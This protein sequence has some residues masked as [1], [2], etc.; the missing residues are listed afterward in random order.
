MLPGL[1]A[2]PAT[3][4]H[5]PVIS[6]IDDQPRNGKSLAR[7]VSG[8]FYTHEL[9]GRH[10]SAAMAER[11]ATRNSA[12]TSLID[13]FCGDGRL[14]AWLL[15]ALRPGLDKPLEIHLWD[16]DNDAVA[17][18]V[19]KLQG[20]IT[21]LELTADVHAWVG[22]TFTRARDVTQRFDAVITN[23]PWELLKPDRRELA[24]MSPE[25]AKRHIADIRRLDRSLQELYPTS[26]PTKRFAGW[27]TNLARVGTEVAL[28]LTAE[29][30]VCGVVS[31]S[32]LFA[33]S[34]SERLRRWILD[35]FNLAEIAYFPAEA[36]LFDSVDVPCVTLVAD[37]HPRAAGSVRM[38]RFGASRQIIDNALVQPSSTWLQSGAYVLPVSLGPTGVHILESLSQLPLFGA[39]EDE[40]LWAG[41]EIDETQRARF[42]LPQ[43]NHPFYKGGNIRR[44]GILN[45]VTEFIDP[46]LVR[47]PAS[48]GHHRLVWRDVSRPN[49]KRR[50]QATLIPPGWVTGNSLSV[51]YLRQAE[52]VEELARLLGL[53][54]SIPFEYQLRSILSTGH[55]SLTSVRRVRLPDLRGNLSVKAL[56]EPVLRALAGD[57]QAETEVEV[58]AARAYGIDRATWE[59][60]FEAFT[61]VS[62]AERQALLAAWDKG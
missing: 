6:E 12:V 57:P 59:T 4:A 11:A 58:L 14:V 25:Q 38:V 30:G 24:A 22:D 43:G 3:P 51:A 15:E 52:D 48:V 18:A 20:A 1:D 29:H 34:N 10:L 55:V 42:L 8:S 16:I 19:T 13:P 26:L 36:K 31:P 47:L 7:R 28:T 53:V 40:V 21:R 17:N 54:A 2:T 32:S 44:F 60:M 45:E 9:I 23:P 41:R 61:K 37:T 33:D 56:A 49:Q 46:L 27:G 50:V 5:L 39:L 62:P 35:E